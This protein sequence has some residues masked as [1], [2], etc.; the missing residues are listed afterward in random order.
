MIFPGGRWA[1][2]R[3][4]IAGFNIDIGTFLLHSEL[5]KGIILSMQIL[6]KLEMFKTLDGYL[7]AGVYTPSGEMLGG[8]TDV[9]GVSFEIAGS[10]FHDAFLF[11]DNHSVEAG[12]GRI[13]M[14]QANTEAGIVF[15]QCYKDAEVH[16]HIILVM[17]K[18]A[19]VAKA[20][21][22]MMK[23]VASLKEEFVQLKHKY[24]DVQVS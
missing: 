5:I 14:V 2:I 21:M 23:V 9:A 17:V 22:T 6:N 18:D 11:A 10:L 20:K 12:F 7:G 19:N 3:G 1:D 24:K 4:S 15:G 16:F 13:D 8:V